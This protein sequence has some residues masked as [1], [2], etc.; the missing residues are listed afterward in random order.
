[1]AQLVSMLMLWVMTQ[2]PLTNAGLLSGPGQGAANGGSWIFATL[3]SE[4]LLSMALDT[5]QFNNVLNW[6]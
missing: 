6:I 2:G 5:S 3:I 1:M 4:I